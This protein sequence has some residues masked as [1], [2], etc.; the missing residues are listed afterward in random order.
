MKTPSP[1]PKSGWSRTRPI[2]RD[3]PPRRRGGARFRRRA[4]PLQLRR[5]T[6]AIR[7]SR[8]ATFASGAWP[9]G[10]RNGR[11]AS[12]GTRRSSTPACPPPGTGPELR[13]DQTPGRR[14]RARQPSG[15]LGTPG[16]GRGA[17][18]RRL[19]RDSSGGSP[20]AGPGSDGSGRIGVAGRV[21]AGTLRR[22]RT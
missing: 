7:C 9:P 14:Q 18:L 8:V 5:F 4:V 17:V 20:T 1:W 13:Q 3:A 19:T 15:V 6:A 12:A 2:R 11:L 22:E 21:V 10:A 16:T